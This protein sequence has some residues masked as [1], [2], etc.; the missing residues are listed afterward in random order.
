MFDN[1]Y[2]FCIFKNHIGEK[3]NNNIEFNNNKN[4]ALTF[5]EFDDDFHKDLF[6]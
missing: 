5:Y 6:P 3:G 4:T 1:G 2:L